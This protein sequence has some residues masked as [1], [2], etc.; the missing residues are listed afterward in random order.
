MKEFYEFIQNVRGF[1]YTFEIKNPSE[2]D[3]EFKANP[4]FIDTALALN[5]NLLEQYI[6]EGRNL[7]NAIDVRFKNEAEQIVAALS[8]CEL[9]IRKF[10]EDQGD[11][12]AIK[13]YYLELSESVRD[14]YLSISAFTSKQNQEFN[15]ELFQAWSATNTPHYQAWSN[16]PNDVKLIIFVF[17]SQA[18]NV[19]DIFKFRL[20]NKEAYGI[21]KNFLQATI[22]AEW[23]LRYIEDNF[24]D[25]NK[26]KGLIYFCKFT[27]CFS[28]WKNSNSIA[29]LAYALVTQ[30]INELNQEQLQ[31]LIVTIEQNKNHLL[32]KV[33]TSLKLT[34]K[35]LDYSAQGYDL[36]ESGT[37]LSSDK[38]EKKRNWCLEF[39]NIQKTIVKDRW[40]E[41][42]NDNL[43]YSEIGGYVNLSQAK[44]GGALL[45]KVTLSG[46]NLEGAD[47]R[48]ADITCSDLSYANLYKANLSHAN[49]S[50]CLLQETDATEAKLNNSKINGNTRVVKSK[51][52]H[53]DFRG[54]TF[55]AIGTYQCDFSGAIFESGSINSYDENSNFTST[56]W[57]N[58]RITGKL[59]GSIFH[60]AS[61]HRVEICSDI[62]GTD[63]SEAALVHSCFISREK[64]FSGK[65]HTATYSSP[66]LFKGASI[67][68]TRKALQENKEIFGNNNPF[69]AAVI[70]LPP[71]LTKD[72]LTKT[73]ERYNL[74]KNS[75]FLGLRWLASSELST[76]TLKCLSEIDCD[77]KRHDKSLKYIL[78]Y[79]EAAFAQALFEVMPEETQKILLEGPNFNNVKFL[80]FAKHSLKTKPKSTFSQILIE[81]IIRT[82]S[83]ERQNELLPSSV[84]ELPQSKRAFG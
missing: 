57:F 52:N 76:A 81:V 38:R 55:Y 50:Q 20:L 64:S 84:Q 34:V 44:L 31:N 27:R 46:A 14:L 65:C 12:V 24:Y 72:K 11:N 78:E 36:D 26:I 67:N 22:G 3:D 56:Q 42:I 48:R 68:T 2:F 5:P 77:E 13:K 17:L 49:L 16:V 25:H 4:P 30:N 32:H 74:F 8:S 60:K 66:P 28:N 59:G 58:T 69:S 73:V 9:A 63:F 62:S 37:G 45:C 54:T 7:L 75:S 6:Q 83:Q 61:L 51:F 29:Y 21:F 71:A 80:E 79:P 1:F 39:I 41:S 82:Q 18:K 23:L 40:D 10:I 15:N 35:V 70:I 47:L 43:I 33:L 19:K 53:V